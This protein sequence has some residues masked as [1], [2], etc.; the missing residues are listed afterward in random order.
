MIKKHLDGAAGISGIEI[1]GPGF[2][3]ITLETAAAGALVGQ[4]VAA[5][6]G[7]RRRGRAGRQAGQPGI[8]LGQPDRA[9]AHRRRPVGGGR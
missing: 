3:N 4:I 8:R 7:V 6:A 9:G 1:A 2:L 5:G